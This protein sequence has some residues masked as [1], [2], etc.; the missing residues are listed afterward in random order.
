MNGERFCVD[1]RTYEVWRSYAD[2]DEFSNSQACSFFCSYVSLRVEE[3]DHRKKA[4]IMDVSK[5]KRKSVLS[6]LVQVKAIGATASVGIDTCFLVVDV[7][8]VVLLYALVENR[9]EKI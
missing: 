9:L 1:V 8:A 2:L 3:E 6:D 5:T 7:L 4:I